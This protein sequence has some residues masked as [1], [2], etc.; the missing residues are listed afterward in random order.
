[1]FTQIEPRQRPCQ[2]FLLSSQ[3]SA[4]QWLVPILA[5]WST[6]GMMW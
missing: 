1:M 3:F 4:S 2:L 6:S 5:A